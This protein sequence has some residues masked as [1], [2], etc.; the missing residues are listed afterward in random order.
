MR[1]AATRIRQNDF[2]TMLG[3]M[4]QMVRNYPGASLLT[5]VALGFLLTRALSRD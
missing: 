5:A 1:G 2:R 4:Q 3:N